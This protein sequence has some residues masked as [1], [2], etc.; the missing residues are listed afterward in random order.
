[1]TSAVGSQHVLLAGALLAVE[2]GAVAVGQAVAVVSAVVV[3]LLVCLLRAAEVAGLADLVD[4]ADPEVLAGAV[5]LVQV[6]AVR[7]AAFFQRAWKLGSLN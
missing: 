5:A 4:V 1:M 2:E 3:P 6:S 7:L